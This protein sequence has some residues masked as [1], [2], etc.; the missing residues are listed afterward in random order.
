MFL[1]QKFLLSFFFAGLVCIIN[2]LIKT[3]V[4]LFKTYCT[5][6]GL[7]WWCRHTHTHT[8]THTKKT[9]FT[10]LNDFQFSNWL[11]HTCNTFIPGARTCGRF[12]LLS[13]II[14]Y[15]LLLL[16]SVCYCMSSKILQ[17]LAPG[18]I[19]NLTSTDTVTCY[20]SFY[21]LSLRQYN[22]IFLIL[23]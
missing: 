6:F 22:M 15:R 21:I 18:K 4:L 3:K 12:S 11:F 20:N 8:H 23:H 16:L 5:N 1:P 10:I 7:K 17:G 2:A 13:L 9:F 19:V 14:F